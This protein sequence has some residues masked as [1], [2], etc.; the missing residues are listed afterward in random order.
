MKKFVVFLDSN[1]YDAANYSFG[2]SQFSKL[3]ELTDQDH[4]T[5][6]INSVV[7]GEVKKHIKERIIKVAK[8]FNKLVSSREFASFRYEEE[9]SNKIAKIDPNEMYLITQKRFDEYLE[10]CKAVIV[11]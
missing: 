1:I 5:L 8:E 11:N 10:S 4:I 6:L 7:E 9:Y 2:N 3:C